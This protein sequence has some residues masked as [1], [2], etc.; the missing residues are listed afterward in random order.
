[1]LNVGP[2]PDGTWSEEVYERL[3]KIGAWM[4][5]NG[6]AIYGTKGREHFKEGKI[7]FT[8]S[9]N[10]SVNAV[11]LADEDEDQPPAELVIRGVKSSENT[12]VEMLGYGK[13]EWEKVSGGLKVFIPEKIRKSPPCD[14][15]WSFKVSE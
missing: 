15:A 13:L 2:A 1:M 7:R 8:V 14:Y 11:Y 5:V 12:H 10:G 9:K 3:D 6:T 4:N